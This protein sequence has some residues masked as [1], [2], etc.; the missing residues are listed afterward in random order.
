MTESLSSLPPWT[1]PPLL[2]QC[3]HLPQFFFIAE[4]LAREHGGPVDALLV[5]HPDAH[6]YLKHFP[7]FRHVNFYQET[8][9]ET[10]KNYEEVLFPLL[11]RGYFRIKS[12]VYSKNVNCW[13]VD[14]EGAIQ[15][16]SRAR[17]F[18][19]FLLALH[20]ANEEFAEYLKAFPHRPMG[21]RILFLESCHP[22]L[23][24]N[25]RGI[26]GKALPDPAEVTRVSE[27][28]YRRSWK[29]FREKRFDAAIVFFSGEKGFLGLKL[30]PFLLRI[31]EI[32]VINEHGHHF[33]A[34]RRGLT[35]FLYQRLVHGVASPRG[36][37]LILLVQTEG[38]LYVREA[39]RRL[40]RPA[41]FP[42]SRI[43]LLCR[44]E[45][46]PEFRESPDID[47][48]FPLEPGNLRK[49]F[50]SVRAIWKM[51]PDFSCAIFSGRKVF[52]GYKIL[53]TL[54]GGRRKL[55]FNA[56]LDCYWLKLRT[57]RRLFRGDELLYY[58]ETLQEKP[59]EV[60]LIQTESWEYTLH[61]IRA[62]KRPDLFPRCRITLVCRRNDRE[63]FLDDL[64]EP[65]LILF[66]RGSRREL[67]QLWR[68]LRG[69]SP[70]I[71]TAVLTGRGGFRKQKL[72]FF[73]LRR[74][75]RLIFNSRLDCYWL[76]LRAFPRIFRQE[77]LLFEPEADTT[78]E[79]LLIQ[80]EDDETTSKAIRITVSGKVVPNKKIAILCSQEKQSLFEKNP[81]LE[82]IYTYEPRKW[83]SNLR[84]LWRVVSRD[85]DVIAALFTGRPIYRFQKL[86]FFALPARHRLVF[87]E[88][89]DCFYLKRGR[90]SQFLRLPSLAAT[91]R[92]RTHRGSGLTLVLRQIART[93][94]F[95]PRFLY[96][97]LWVTFAKLRRSY[98][99]QD[100][101]RTK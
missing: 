50:R 54:L 25:T 88:N 84:M 29:P 40:R 28:S 74:T 9:L 21:K 38:P 27:F 61:A 4:K 36:E 81:F 11:N 67:F 63:K 43:L 91:L 20:E 41:L 23:I 14:Y 56:G 44:N 8:S 70:D 55:V 37:P 71:I 62:L 30:L 33:Y 16:L 92:H 66:Q 34:N 51:A 60:L 76:S 89:L 101:T 22:S 83:L 26:W 68:R 12:S 1:S 35:R 53:F 32:L 87:N 64:P 39:A 15:P 49:N 90:I 94:L 52:T 86:L 82:S 17:Y 100:P 42:G 85:R 73:L 72:L 65:S 31:G 57:L 6:Y 3:C 45:D 13:E 97:L 47:E 75:P 2:V 99:L 96:L 79:V 58:R 93:I 7:H 78:S 18:R 80:T 59:L 69:I 98:V 77:P 46:D 24:E 95:L 19:S 5:D 10:V 48:V